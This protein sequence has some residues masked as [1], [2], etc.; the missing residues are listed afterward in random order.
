MSLEKVTDRLFHTK[1]GNMIVSALFGVGFA[2]MFSRAC[3]GA[4]CVVIHAPKMEEVKDKV[5][6]IQDE[7]FT[8]TPK[9]VSCNS[10]TPTSRQ[11]VPN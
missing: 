5:F 6:Q 9:M 4:N 8:Y 2:F 1:P 3:K 10:G 7:C 11:F